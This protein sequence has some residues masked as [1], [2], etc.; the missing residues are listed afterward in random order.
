MSTTSVNLDYNHPV[1]GN[2]PP[3]DPQLYQP[4]PSVGI[5][6]AHL[7]GNFDPA[8]IPAPNMNP[9]SINVASV[10]AQNASV[11]TAPANVDLATVIGILTDNQSE[12]QRNLI[13]VMREVAHRPVIAAP[14]SAA[15]R[16][17]TVKLRNARIFSGKHAEVTPFLSEI[18][19][20]IEFNSASFPDDHT[21]VLFV[22]LNMKDGIPIEWFNHLEVSKSVLLWNW[23]NFLV[24][25]RKKFADPS[26]ITT[27]D[28]R[29]DQL[30]QTGSAHYY[31]TSFMELASHLDMT[32]QTKISRFMKGLKPSVKDHLVTIVN[33]PLT[34]EEWEPLVISIDSN[35]HQRDIERRLEGNS[36]AKNGFAKKKKEKDLSYNTTNSAMYVPPG[37]TTAPS[38]DVVP[39]DVDAITTSTS[40]APRGKLTPAERDLRFKNKL[41]L[42]CGKP[43]HVV[44]DCN[45]RKAKH[46]EQGKA[47]PKTT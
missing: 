3:L 9:A 25:F 37:A 19:R 36:N 27:A 8:A 2:P 30:K 39:M 44:N 5:D 17:S 6:F 26:L 15:P 23:N 47:K 28:Q 34:L 29:L 21:K 43:N 11:P 31:L 46:G 45:A 12:L 35:L 7:P 13:D 10:P 1:T 33:R 14:T 22:G 41:C 38:S 20:I 32:E 42:Y 24:A 4:N 18:K 16:G 40:S